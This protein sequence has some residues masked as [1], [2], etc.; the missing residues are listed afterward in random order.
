MKKLVFAILMLSFIPAALSAICAPF[1]FVPP[2][3]TCQ[4]L[5]MTGWMDLQ[6]G[7][8][9]VDSYDMSTCGP[10][11]G[12]E[13]VLLSGFVTDGS[14]TSGIRPQDKLLLTLIDVGSCELYQDDSSILEELPSPT[15]V[16][17]T[18]TNTGNR[19]KRVRFS[20]QQVLTP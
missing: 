20:F 4:E 9:F 13:S 1:Y 16:V 18:V 5:V 12:G 10:V 17:I 2:S 11:A 6:P 8:S 3:G 15:T 7:E 14:S 19:V